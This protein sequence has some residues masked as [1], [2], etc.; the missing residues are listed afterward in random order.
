MK[1]RLSLMEWG[2]DNLCRPNTPQSSRRQK[3]LLL[4]ASL[5][6]STRARR[7]CLEKGTAH[8]DELATK[9]IEAPTDKESPTNWLS[10]T[11][12]R[13]DRRLYYLSKLLTSLLNRKKPICPATSHLWYSKVFVGVTQSQ[14]SALTSLMS[15]HLG[16]QVARRQPHVR[17]SWMWLKAT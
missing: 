6:S 15:Q 16:V 9:Q 8:M 3:L 14:L 7:T 4:A 2:F 5:F 1:A 17:P 12:T 11:L 10:R 13:P